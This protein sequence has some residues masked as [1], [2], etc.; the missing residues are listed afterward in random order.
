ML[1]RTYRVKEKVQN[2]DA[3]TFIWE[4]AVILS[5]DSYWCLTIKQSDWP[6]S[7]I[8]SVPEDRKK[9]QQHGK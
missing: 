4:S 6:A 1:S 3:V 7:D 8:F 2:L 5:L 9:T